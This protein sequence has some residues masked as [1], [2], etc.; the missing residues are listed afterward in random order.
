MIAVFLVTLGMITAVGDVEPTE[1]TRRPDLVG[2]EVTIDDRVRYFLESKRGKGYDQLNFKRT[3]ALFR[4]PANLKYT[5]PPS[6]AN[7]RV[8][9]ILKIE[10]GR[11]VVDVLKIDMLPGDLERLEREIG[12][13]RQDDF[14][15]RRTWALWAEKRGKELSEP[16]LEARGVVLEIEAVWLEASRPETDALG[17]FSRT[18]GRPI[19]ESVRFALAHRGFRDRLAKASTIDDLEAL[20]KQVESTIPASADSRGSAN[21]AADPD[22]LAAYAKN[23]GE[24]YREAPD[25][26]RAWLDRRLL[27]DIA[28]RSI[29]LQVKASPAD[30][31]KLAELARDRLPDRPEVVD[32]LAKQALIEAES[33]VASMRQSEVEELAS[34]FRARG[35]DD[36]ANRLIRS[37][38]A[39][40]RKNRLSA[41]DAEGRI[42]LAANY[43]K[44]LGDRATSAELLREALAIDPASRAAAEAFLRM[45]F[46]RGESGWY[47]PDAVVAS[48]ANL[49]DRVS[50]PEPGMTSTDLGDSLRG[51]TR[52]QVRSRLGGKPDQIIRSASQG[53]CV[54]QWIYQNGRGTQVVRF[55]FEASKTEPR[56][57]VSYSDRK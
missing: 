41:S 57:S 26:V 25:G 21:S 33:K 7:A 20:A 10:E 12:R 15:G 13:L 50:K 48:P 8:T 53:R 43:D 19:P 11:P 1:L 47:D 24:T 35:E 51:L 6:E 32:R 30:A 31:A 4:L 2:R 18:S 14:Q 27:A 38:L 3:D 5:R 9:G 37:W 39:D 49:P 40:R 34:T 45:G 42:L 22:T 52:A 44:M 36:R 23:P 17:L 46:R 54:E 55:V 16:K 28:Q 29:E 56:A